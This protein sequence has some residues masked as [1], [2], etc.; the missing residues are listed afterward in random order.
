VAL[1]SND[2]NAGAP[3]NP[4]SPANFS[5]L[6]ERARSLVALESYLSFVGNG[7]VIVDGQAENARTMGVSPGLFMMLGRGA[8]VGSALT[9]GDVQHVVMS[10]GFWKRRFGADPQVVGRTLVVDGTPLV[11]SGVMPPDFVFPYK[12]MLGATGFTESIDVDLWTPMTLTGP[13]FV[14]ASGQLVRTTHFLGSVGRLRPGVSVEQARARLGA[15]ASEL[16]REHPDS[17]RGWSI[18]LEPLKDEVVAG[19]RPALLVL[20]AGVVVVLLMACLN[21][22]NLALARAVARRGELALRAAL[23]AGAARLVGEALLEHVLLAAAGAAIGLALALWGV[24][25]LIALAPADLP[26]IAEVHLDPIVAGGAAGVAILVGLVVGLAPALL[27]SRTVARSAIQEIG[28]GATASPGRQRLRSALVVAEIALAVMLTIAAALLMRSFDRLLALDPGFRVDHILTAQM[29]IPDRLTTPAARRAFYATFFERVGAIPG[30]LSTGGTT[31]IPLGSTSVTTT[32]YVE[33]RAVTESSVPT[34]EFRR[35]LGAYF[36]TMGIPVLRGRGFDEH[37]GPDAPP[38]VVVNEALARRIFPGE[39]PVGR[40]VRTGPGGSGP[41]MT[42]VGIVGDVRHRQLEQ[43]PEPE[44]YISSLQNPPVAP[45]IAIRTADDPAETA[46]ALRSAARS[47]DPTLTLFDVRTMEDIHAASLAERRFVL[48]LIGAFG[49]ISLLLAGVGVYGVASLVAVER[50]RE[51]G[52][53]LALGASPAAVLGLI[54]RQ[55]LTLAAAGAAI[56]VGAAAAAAPL[57]ASQL[58]GV[59]PLDPLTLAVAPCVLVGVAALASIVPGWR[60]MRADPVRAL[61]AG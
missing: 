29:N 22:A 59:R 18:T 41:W 57:L 20:M 42:I 36:S 55:T 27:A 46:E 40:H 14:S 23:G 31:R 11:V 39:D 60:A 30:V 10:D 35:A 12:G 19:V 52:V 53:R 17:N 26:R 44:L 28:R 32:L 48:T 56:G 1:W 16:E 24:P 7:K 9:Q 2:T 58:Y 43:Q 25:A 8:A 15:I 3:H 38:V 51:A 34:V 54:V 50:T 49:V 61:N 37:D 33:G 21:V 13:R 5:D 4:I 45:F 6:E 47:I